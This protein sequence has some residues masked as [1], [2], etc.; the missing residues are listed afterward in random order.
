MEFLFSLSQ[1]EFAVAVWVGV[2]VT[3]ALVTAAVKLVS[4]IDRAL[5]RRAVVRARMARA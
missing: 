3:A 4:S 1:D 2:C 5:S